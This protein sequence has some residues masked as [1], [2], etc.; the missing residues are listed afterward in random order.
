MS[1]IRLIA[2]SP[3]DIPADVIEKYDIKVIPAFVNFGL[4]SYADT[5]EEM[6]R[7]EFYRR[8]K[9]VKELPTTAAQPPGLSEEI[10]REA[11]EDADH[12][13]VV[14]ISG[15]L[16]A[17]VQS[18]RVAAEA[19]GDDRIKVIDG[20]GVAMF[21]GWQTIAAAEAVAEG[22]SVEEVL[23][24]IEDTRARTRLWAIPTGLEFLKRS[25]RVSAIVAGIGDMLQLKP[26]IE[27]ENGEAIQ[28]SRVR[29]EKNI[30]KKLV[31]LVEGEAP[32]ERL[33]LI[34]LDNYEG[35]VDLKERLS[36]IAP[37]QTVI[38]QASSAIGANF[39]PGG[40]AIATVR[41]A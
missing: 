37:E 39:G 29:T 1:R 34:H 2:D 31:Q 7:K 9:T 23:Q 18:S 22:K 28:S 19:I 17:M 13:I 40:L 5:E 14:H 6:P 38:T 3:S 24:V 15:K 20:G 33:A 26:V 35:A 8:L 21:V 4:D 32:L 30:P 41:Q 10:L 16:S 27:F 12:V 11:L 25:G 36:D